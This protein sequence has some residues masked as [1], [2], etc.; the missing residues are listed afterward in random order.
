MMAADQLSSPPSLPVGLEVFLQEVDQH[1]QA[2]CALFP[3][4]IGND[5]S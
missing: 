4:W 5:P 3:R 1:Y 2:T